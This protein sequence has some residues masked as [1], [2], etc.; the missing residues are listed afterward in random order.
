MTRPG[1]GAPARGA[2]PSKV[3]SE[4]INP[5]H[6]RLLVILGGVV[7]FLLPLL[8]SVAADDEKP[9]PVELKSFKFPEGMSD[10]FGFN[11]SEEKLFLYTNGKV[12]A[13]FKVT[14]D[15]DYEIVVKASGDAAMDEGAK[16][17]VAVDGK[18]AGKETETAKDGPKEFKF[19]ASIKSGEHELTI[20]FTNDVYKAGEYDRN[21]YVHAVEV[22]RAK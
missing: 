15:G 10:L 22:K 16:F 21:L 2:N 8:A 14:A 11:E 13:K 7:L 4:R 12:T 19:P 1:A 5:M 18:E 3:V 6:I 17:K 9:V 20:E